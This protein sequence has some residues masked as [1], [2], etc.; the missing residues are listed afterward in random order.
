LSMLA[1]C[2]SSSAC[3]RSSFHVM[4]IWC[5]R[6]DANLLYVQNSQTQQESNSKFWKSHRSKFCL[7]YQ[8][9]FHTSDLATSATSVRGLRSLRSLPRHLPF[10]HKRGDVILFYGFHRATNVLSLVGIHYTC[11]INKSL[12]G[13]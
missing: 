3:F 1:L 10:L 5:T 11:N 6:N 4:G 12:K 2:R 13:I 9:N 8:M 7:G